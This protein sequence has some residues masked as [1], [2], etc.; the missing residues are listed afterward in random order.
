MIRPYSVTQQGGC[1]NAI[2][3]LAATFIDDALPSATYYRA[4]NQRIAVAL[5]C[6]RRTALG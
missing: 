4:E 5:Y 3:L 1:P 2:A 6:A